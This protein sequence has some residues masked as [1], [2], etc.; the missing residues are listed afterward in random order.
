MCIVLLYI[1]QTMN[2]FSE[3]TH[4]SLITFIAVPL[5]S[6]ISGSLLIMFLA[7]FFIISPRKSL[8]VLSLVVPLWSFILN[9]NF[10]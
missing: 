9:N 10:Q 1:I 3:F 5:F 4:I 2:L 6:F 8:S 7:M